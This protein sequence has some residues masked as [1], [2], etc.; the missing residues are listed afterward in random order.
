MEHTAIPVPS[1]NPAPKMSALRER[2]VLGTGLNR[3]EVTIFTRRNGTNA[4]Q[5]NVQ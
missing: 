3:R 5:I 2:V 1:V 4:C